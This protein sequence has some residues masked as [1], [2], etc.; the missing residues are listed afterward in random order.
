MGTWESVRTLKISE[1][2][3]RGQNTSHCAVHYIIGKTIET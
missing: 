1:F 3:C 2:N